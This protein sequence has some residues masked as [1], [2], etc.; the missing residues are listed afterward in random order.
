MTEE[1]LVASIIEDGVLLFEDSEIGK[2]VDEFIRRDYPFQTEYGLRF[3]KA[4]VLD[5]KKVSRNETAC[6]F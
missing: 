1:S 4:A 6:E 5:K 2:A 3:V